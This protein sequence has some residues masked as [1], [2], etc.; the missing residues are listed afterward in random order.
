MKIK[1]QELEDLSKACEP[2]ISWLN[3]IEADPHMSIVVDKQGAKVVRA[4][5]FT[6]FK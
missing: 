3:K 5:A 6:P 1:F 4:E 2:L